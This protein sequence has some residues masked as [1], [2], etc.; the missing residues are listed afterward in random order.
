MKPQQVLVRGLKAD[1]SVGVFDA[2]EL[3]RES[4]KAFVLDLL[5]HAKL[6][7]DTETVRGVRA[8]EEAAIGGSHVVYTQRVG[9]RD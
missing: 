1:G 5:V 9:S 8:R 3:D 4:F 2:L 7:P 6:V